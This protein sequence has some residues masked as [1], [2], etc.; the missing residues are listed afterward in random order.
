MV[1]ILNYLGDCSYGLSGFLEITLQSQCPCL[2][3]P[4]IP[5][6]SVREVRTTTVAESAAENR[7][8]SKEGFCRIACNVVLPVLGGA[9]SLH[10]SSARSNGWFK[11]LAGVTMGH[12]AWKPQIAELERGECSAEGGLLYN[13]HFSGRHKNLAAKCPTCSDVFHTLCFRV[14]DVQDLRKQWHFRRIPHPLF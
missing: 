13:L 7:V 10:E 11:T 2:F 14:F 9:E 12:K 3:N 5:L 6:R 1:L 4:T 8:F